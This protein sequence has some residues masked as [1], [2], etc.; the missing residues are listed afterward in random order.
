MNKRKLFTAI[1]AAVCAVS[2]SACSIKFGTNTKPAADEVAAKPTS[3]EFADSMIITYGEFDK[4]YQYYLNT[5]NIADD[6][7]ESV[8]EACKSQR[9][10]IIENLV[11]ER[12]LLNKAEEYG[13]AELTDDENKQ[14][15]DAYDAMVSQA[16][17]YYGEKADYGTLESGETVSDEEKQQ[18]GTEEFNKLLEK[19]GLT[20]DDI[21]QWQKN[22][23]IVT[24]LQDKVAEASDYS[25]AEETFNG[26]VEQIK[27]IYN[28]DVSAY[29]SG[30]YST[31][32]I[33]EGSRNVKHILLGFDDDT[34]SEIKELRT[35]G[36]DEAADKLR[37]E[38]AEELS[39]K[40][41]EVEQKL[42]EGGNWDELIVEYSDDTAGSTA[43]P[44][45]YLVIPNGTN[46]MEEF[47]NAAMEM[48]KVG[49]RTT[50]VT[51]YGVHIM[52]YV[53]D[54]ELSDEDKKN[55][56]DYLY[57]QQQQSDFYALLS[58]WEDEFAYEISYDLLKIDAP[59]EDTQDIS[60][61]A[62]TKATSQSE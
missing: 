32:W 13:V 33:P 57:S 14:A 3:G 8:A 47:Q 49:D 16:V 19:S 5:K 42:D 59:V 22:S 1:T 50:C 27:E 2:L 25:K 6:T 51:D 7:D 62:E 18:R 21:L 17:T 37:A 23:I 44:D 52:T 26:Y 55:I 60:D 12:I 36:D 31:F 43:Y 40:V 28:N 41:K 10:S 46:Y 38:K 24:K 54:A 56:T 53:S 4:E 34:Q 45:G 11:L 30:Y 9:S 61:T 29:Q 20:N 35:D 15:Q 39:D 58:Q 48:K